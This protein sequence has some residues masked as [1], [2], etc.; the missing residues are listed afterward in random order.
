MG[1]CAYRGSARSDGKEHVSVSQATSLMG[2][3]VDE[4]AQPIV[5]QWSEDPFIWQ[6]ER[7]H[8]HILFHGA[9][10]PQHPVGGHAFSRHLAGPWTLSATAPYSQTVQFADGHSKKMYRRERPQ[11]LLSATGQPR[12][13]SSG[14]MDV[15]PHTYTLVMRVQ[16]G[17]D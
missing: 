2:P 9:G 14:V 10:S 16:T 7:G 8:W 13:F 6:D 17:D 12:Y 5:G 15:D 11:L 1:I 4:R 3:Y